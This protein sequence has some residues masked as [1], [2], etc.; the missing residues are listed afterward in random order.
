MF[1]KINLLTLGKKQLDEAFYLLYG[2]ISLESAQNVTE[3]ILAANYAEEP[4]EVLTLIINSQGGD[5]NAAWAII[6]IMRGSTIPVRV[7]GLGQIVSAGLLIFMSGEKGMRILSE[8]TT[9]MSHQYF[10]GSA[11]KYHEL[12]AVQK[13][14]DLTQTRLIKHFKKIT[15]LSEKDI[16]KYLM[17]AHDVYMSAEEAKKLNLCD[18]IKSLK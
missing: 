7:I 12:M 16:D 9:V 17:P 10:W 8:N 11:G 2:D 3:W 1:D 18:E 13:E 4:P 6:D 15:G 14:F 5:L